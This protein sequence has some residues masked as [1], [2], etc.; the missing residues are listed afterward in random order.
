MPFVVAV[1]GQH[2]QVT[3]PQ[4]VGPGQMV[5]LQVP[6]VNLCSWAQPMNSGP[7]TMASAQIVPLHGPGAIFPT[8][9]SG[10][11]STGLFDIC[12]DAEI[13]LYGC[14]CSYCA[15]GSVSGKRGSRTILPRGA[16]VTSPTRPSVWPPPCVQTAPPFVHCQGRHHRPNRFLRLHTQSGSLTTLHPQQHCAAQIKAQLEGGGC[17]G[18]CCSLWAIDNCFGPFSCCL[19]MGLRSAMRSM[20]G[21]PESPCFMCPCGRRCSDCCVWTCC[22]S[23]AQVRGEGEG[24]A[25]PSLNHQ[26]AWGHSL[27]THTAVRHLSPGGA[28]SFRVF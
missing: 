1:N 10:Q 3:C 2:V 19:R 9:G 23:C 28:K 20:W 8:P 16:F 5:Q 12:A 17:C 24:A 15:S 6:V 11:W 14:C 26:K 22:G 13:F 18:Y 4:G 25:R 7:S 27:S 21:L